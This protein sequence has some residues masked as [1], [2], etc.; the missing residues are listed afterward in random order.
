MIRLVAYKKALIAGA[1]GA[2]VWEVVVRGFVA[3]GFP[4][5]DL[6]HMLGRMTL[7]SDAEPWEWWTAGM[8]MHAVVGAIW[9]VFYAYFF[10]SMFDRPPVLQGIIFSLLPMVLA[11]LIMVPQMDLMDQQV[12]SGA[13]QRNSFFAFKLGFG[14]PAAIILG[15]LVYGAVLGYLYRDPVGYPAGRKILSYG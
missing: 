6:V 10:W 12:L 11:G 13:A 5:F 9:A 15:H 3:A 14:G 1:L 4:M 8:S 7:G 2:A